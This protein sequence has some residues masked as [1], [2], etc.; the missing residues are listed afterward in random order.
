MSVWLHNP[1]VQLLYF[2]LGVTAGL[3]LLI[4]W[5]QLFLWRRQTNAKIQLIKR[6]LEGAAELIQRARIAKE[7]RGFYLQ[8]S[9]PLP[10]TGSGPFRTKDPQ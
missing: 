5:I 1:W 8:N 4:T 3:F 7:S 6:E 2:A 9:F 10:T